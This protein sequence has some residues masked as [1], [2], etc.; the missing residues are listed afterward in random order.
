MSLRWL[1]LRLASFIHHKHKKT[2]ISHILTKVFSKVSH[3]L[4][5]AASAI[6]TFHKVNKQRHSAIAI[7]FQMWLVRDYFQSDKDYHREWIKKVKSTLWSPY[8]ALALGRSPPLPLQCSTH[9]PK[10]FLTKS[11]KFQKSKS[12]F[13][14]VNVVVFLL[15][16]RTVMLKIN[17]STSSS[18]KTNI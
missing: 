14:P 7:H 16:L 12:W 9:D 2:W 18:I 4:C 3:K 8:W 5:F 1:K 6:F 15:L 11:P 13:L 17:E 10:G